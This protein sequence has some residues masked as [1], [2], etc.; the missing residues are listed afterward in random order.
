MCLGCGAGLTQAG[1]VEVVHTVQRGAG[2]GELFLDCES[3]ELML[4]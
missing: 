3:R 4:M 1:A 2:I